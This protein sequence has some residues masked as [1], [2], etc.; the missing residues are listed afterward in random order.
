[1]RELLCLII[2]LFAQFGVDCRASDSRLVILGDDTAI[3]RTATEL[4]A[5]AVRQSGYAPSLVVLQAN[6]SFS[7]AVIE[8]NTVVIAVGVRAH[9][10]AAKIVAGRPLLSILVTRA[11]LDEHPLPVGERVSAIVLDQPVER[12]AALIQLAFPAARRVGVLA[13]AAGTRPLGPLERSL[14][15]K[16]MRLVVENVGGT[17]GLLPAI[18]RLVPNIDLFLALP[19]PVVHNRNTVQSL[20]LTTYRAGIPVIAYSEAYQQAGAALALYST[21]PQIVSQAVDTLRSFRDGRP[22]PRLQAPSQFT[23]GVNTVVARSLGLRLPPVRE[24]GERLRA[25]D[26]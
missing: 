10:V 22:V 19:D 9:A 18:E 12:W 20:L 1:M 6:E 15:E 2:A 13:G 21:I 25:V 26:Q 5:Q 11:A 7:P 3:A 16:R 8:A 24:L 4:L 23:V 14:G 17:E